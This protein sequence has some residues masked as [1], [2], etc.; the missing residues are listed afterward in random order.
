MNQTPKKIPEVGGGVISRPLLIGAT[1]FA[2]LAFLSSVYG[3]FQLLSP[4]FRAGLINNMIADGILQQS[5][6]QTWF[7]VDCMLRGFSVLLAGMLTAVCGMILLSLLITPEGD[8]P[9]GEL[10]AL[11]WGARILS[12][13]EC[14]LGG[15]LTILFLWRVTLYG[16][17]CYDVRGGGYSFFTMLA[18][19]VVCL[20]ALLGTGIWFWRFMNET[21]DVCHALRRGFWAHIL[22]GRSITPFF[23]RSVLSF[24]ILWT[25]IG[26]F[27]IPDWIGALAAG[28]LGISLFYLYLLLRKLKEEMEW[29]EYR[30]NKEKN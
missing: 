11:A 6:Q 18:V 12:V 4:S 1:V 7:T 20:L 17:A 3:C 26:L 15:V 30:K 27:R 9:L 5:A 13:V 22:V 28:F 23:N 21:I 2:I 24:S 29:L 14:I 16:F 19:E 25:V 8:L 10:S